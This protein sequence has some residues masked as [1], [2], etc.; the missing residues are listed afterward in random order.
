MRE[1]LSLLGLAQRAGAVIDGDKRVLQAM[2]SP[3]RPLVFMAS[4]IGKN[5]RKKILDKA[6]TYDIEVLD[7]F[8]GATL[9][10]AVGKDNRKTL[11]VIDERFIEQIGRRMRTERVLTWQRED[12]DRTT[13]DNKAERE[14]DPNDRRR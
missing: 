12:Q 10:K 8:D 1:M 5:N 13:K 4:D 14:G 2:R 6:A 7:C 3:R 9:S 11:A